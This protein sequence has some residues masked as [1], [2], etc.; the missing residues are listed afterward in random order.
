[1]KWNPRVSRIGLAAVLLL[2]G[3]YITLWWLLGDG[4][5]DSANTGAGT[6][7]AIP[8]Y[9]N[10]SDI[11]TIFPVLPRDRIRPIYDPEFVT[12]QQAR[13]PDNELVMG[14][15]IDGESRAYPIFTLNAREMVN[16]TVAGVP[17]LVTW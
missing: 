2:V 16:D 13:M 5:I 6:G 12:A 15:A 3:G 1:M 8:S 4:S 10:S 17:I 7:A 9:E 11:L 14:V